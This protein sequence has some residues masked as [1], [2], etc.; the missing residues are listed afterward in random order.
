MYLPTSGL[1]LYGPS[2]RPMR[3]QISREI[4]AVVLHRAIASAELRPC[5]QF[6]RRLR[7]KPSDV[8]GRYSATVLLQTRKSE[9][10]G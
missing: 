8:R 4:A 10:S 3:R 6:A 7:S 2:M 9:Y 5:F 1:L